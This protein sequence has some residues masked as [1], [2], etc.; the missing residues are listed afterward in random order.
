MK[1]AVCLGSSCHVKGSPQ[2]IE[3]LRKAI[4]ENNLEGK[5]EIEGSI[6]LGECAAKGVNMK[7]DDEVITGITSEN[8]SELFKTRILGTC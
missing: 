2:I 8:F 6:C 7:I 1:I 5:V 3:M 4:K